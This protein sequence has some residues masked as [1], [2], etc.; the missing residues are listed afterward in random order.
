MDSKNIGKKFMKKN[1]IYIITGIFHE[2]STDLVANTYG[3]FFEKEKAL[4]AAKENTGSMDEC[5][6]NYLVIEEVEPGIY[7]NPRTE[8]WYKWDEKSKSWKDSPKPDFSIGFV[9][10]FN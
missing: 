3:Y 5:Y 6:F 1:Y 8:I 10:W 7:T 2:D 4:K 9:N